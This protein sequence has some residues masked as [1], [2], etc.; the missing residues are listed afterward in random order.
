MTTQ[1]VYLCPEHPEKPYTSWRKFRG[2]W[3]TQHRGEECPPREDFLQEMEKGEARE[4]KDQYKEDLKETKEKVEV[5]TKAVFEGEFTLPEEPVPKLAK[6]LEV[7]GVPEDI[8]RQVLGVF[9]LHP[10]YRDNPTNLHYLL[11]TKLPRK[12][13]PSIPLMTS[14][15]M[16]SDA[17]YPEG[18]PIMGGFGMQGP[19]IMP[20]LGGMGGYPPYYPPS[21][22][23]MPNFRQP[24]SG[25]ETEE[26]ER[27]PRR[28]EDPMD[29]MKD[30]IAMMGAMFE[31]MGKV[32]GNRTEETEKLSEDLRASY[33]GLRNTLEEATQA[34]RAEKEAMREEFSKK[35]EEVT[36]A[37]RAVIEETKNALHRTELGRLEDRITTLQ[38]SKDEERSEGLGSLLKEAGEGIGSQLEG[39]RTSVTQGVEKVGTIVEKVV[40]TEGLPKSPVGRG[41]GRTSP[42]NVNEASELLSIEMEIEELA[43]SLEEGG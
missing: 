36:E 26:E 21:Y 8:V 18:I 23:Y 9:Q 28:R 12:F 6:I 38:E 4:L 33:E 3:S 35:V 2:H 7:N 16:S 17:S 10:A 24:I 1:R 27:R 30:T 19:G 25:R 5:T 22:G 39:L 37:S 42:K 20:P 40:S 13:H 29:S 43:G 41:R 31:F 15:F 11:I 14:A 34:S 32:G